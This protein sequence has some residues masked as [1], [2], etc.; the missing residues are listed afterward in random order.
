M[1]TNCGMCTEEEKA[2]VR[3]VTTHVKETRPEMWEEFSDRFDP[4]RKF[5]I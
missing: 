4:D 1:K 3:R 5:E 2:V